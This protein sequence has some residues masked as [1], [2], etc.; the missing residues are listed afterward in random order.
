MQMCRCVDHIDLGVCRSHVVCHTMSG[1]GH[2]SWVAIG[3]GD[4]EGVLEAIGA[5]VR[6]GVIGS[7]RH[8]DAWMLGCI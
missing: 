7:G 6:A 8:V 4:A 2:L 5:K 1:R 3:G